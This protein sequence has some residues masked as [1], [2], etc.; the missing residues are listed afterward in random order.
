MFFEIYKSDES[1]TYSWEAKSEDE[2][3][4][5]SSEPMASRGTCLAAI[6]I[7]KH[8]AKGANVYDQTGD[9]S[10]PIKT[11]RIA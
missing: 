11:R 6:L 3:T 7:L 1:G 4:L 9:L 5:C 8:G 10:G 2:K